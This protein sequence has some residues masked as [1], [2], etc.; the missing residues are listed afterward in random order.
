MFRVIRASS[1]REFLSSKLGT[2]NSHLGPAPALPWVRS[3]RRRIELGTGNWEHGTRSAPAGYTPSWGKLGTGNL[4]LGTRRGPRSCPTL[5]SRG[6][7]QPGDRLGT[8]NRELKAL[9][10]QNPS[11]PA[12]QLPSR[13]LMLLR[14]ATPD[15]RPPWDAY[16][17]G[18]PDGVAYQLF[19][20]KVA[21]ETA[22][23]FKCPY[24]L[25]EEGGEARG[26]LPLVHLLL[27]FSKGKLIPL[28]LCHVPGLPWP[29]RTRSV[30]PLSNGHGIWR[31]KREPRGSS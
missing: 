9:A 26:V 17:L 15:D 14:L 12:S 21:V 10:S 5:G 11:V 30:E 6:T 13:G 23:G 7:P 25:V 31:G 8:G 18:R 29:T 22:Y 19:G 27:P 2:R 3:A 28:P 24:L 4:E 1:V 20:W 16:V